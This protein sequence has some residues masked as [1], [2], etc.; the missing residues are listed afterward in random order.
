MTTHAVLSPSSRHRWQLCAASAREALKYPEGK[1]SPS[2]VDGTH[3]HTLLELCLKTNCRPVVGAILA[4]DD[5]TF[6]VDEAR[7][8]RVNFALDYIHS[9]NGTIKS[10]IKVY[11]KIG[12]DDVSG[13]VDVLITG[14]DT[15]EVIDYKDGVGEVEVENNPQLS[16][17]ALGVLADNL[18]ATTLILTIIQPKLREMGKNP[19]KSIQLDTDSFYNTELDKLKAEAS[20]TDNPDAPYVAGEVQ[21]K[22]CPHGGNCGARAT[23]V[24]EKA[25]ITFGKTTVLVQSMELETMNLTNEKIRDIIEATPMIKQFLETVEEMALEKMVAGNPIDGLKVIK[26]RGTR[27]WSLPDEEIAIKLNKM[28]VPKGELWKTSLISPAQLE[29]LKWKNTKGEQ[30]TLSAKQLGVVKSELIST[31]EGRLT[32]VSAA[33][34]RPAVEFKP[35]EDMFVPDW[36]K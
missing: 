35:V 18:D 10:E 15:V 6:T 1:S 30:K 11:P 3:T 24:L 29:K 25:G 17:Y 21:C 20:A 2:A 7:A 16:Q 8:E 22:W 31:S 23:Q 28:T 5:G 32:V 33:D 4:D 14:T 13:T 12:R 26:G 19:I 9:R 36:M 34:E 27:S